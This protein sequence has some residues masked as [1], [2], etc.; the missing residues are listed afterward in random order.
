MTP[1]FPR[2]LPWKTV[3]GTSLFAATLFVPATAALFTPS[4]FAQTTGGTLSG[5]VTDATGAII[6][7]AP[8]VL[9]NVNSGDTRTLNS[10]SSGV[11]TFAGV[12]S[13]DYSIK[14][15]APGFQTFSESGIHL[16]PGDNRTL[17][18]LALKTG[19][20]TQTVTVEAQTDVP[21]DNGELSDLITS[22]EIKHLSVEGRDV[23]ELFKTLPGFAISN[24]NGGV[25]N[26]AYDPSQVNVTGALGSYAAN[27][28]PVSGISLRLDGADITDPGNFGAA[29]QNINYDQVAEVKVQVSNFGADIA[30]GP[31]VVS[32]VTKAGGDHFHGELYAY[33]RTNQL[34]SVDALDKATGTP[35]DPDREV[36]PGFNVGGPV[37]IPGT[38][39]NHN[40]KLTFFAGAEDY[41]QRNIYAYGSA[42][43]ALVHA[44]VPTAA[45]RTGNYSA[46]ELQNYLGPQ[47]YATG[48]ALPGVT[49]VNGLIPGS[50]YQFVDQ[51]PT[52]ASDGTPLANGQL[53]SN[54]QDPG[55]QAIFATYP[56]PNQTAT[57]ANPYNWQ[58]QDLINDDLWQAIGRVDLA[59]SDKNHF[60]GRYSVERG[61][62]GEPTALYYN[63]GGINT[64]GGGLSS[65]NSESA[66]ANLTTIFNS[67]L[68]NQLFG[69]LAYLNQS[70]VSPDPGA[71]TSYPYQGAFANGRHP[72]PQLQTY[73]VSD[74]MPLA[75]F[76][77]YSAGPIFAHKFTPQGGDTVTKVW[78]KHTVDFGVFIERVTNNELGAN[79]TTNGYLSNY[80][81]PNA[82]QTF[83]DVAPAGQ[84][85]ASYTMSGNYV[86]DNAEGFTQT[87]GQ[88]NILPQADLY[89][90]RNDFFAQDSWKMTQ[91]LTF[92]YGMRFEHLG[93]W[94]DAH[95][96]GI[97]IFEPSLLASGSGTSP[98]PGFV[99]HA[100]DP[101]VPNS[102]TASKPL[103]Y[104]GRVGFA[105]DVFG[106]GKTALRGGWGEYRSH[107]SWNDVQAAVNLTVG[108][109]TVTEGG[110]GV[111]LKGVSALNLS[112]APQLAGTNTFGAPTA[113]SLGGTVAPYGLTPGDNQEPL[114]DTYSLSINQA[115]PHHMNALIGYVGNNSRFIMNDGSNETVALDNVNAIPIGGLY[116]PDP[117][118]GSPCY[119]LVLTPTGVTPSGA[120]CSL[121]TAGAGAAQVNDYRPL[122]TPL[123]HYGAIDVPKH[124]L[125]AN[126]NAIQLALSKQTGRILFNLNYTFS[127]ALGILGGYNNGLPGNPFQLLDNYG[128]EAFDRSQI[129]NA[130]YTFELGSPVH[131]KLVGEVTNGWE[132]SGITN[133]QSGPDLTSITTNPGFAVSGTIGQP[134]LA[135]G[136]AN[137]NA[138]TINNAVY[139]GTPDVSLQPTLLCNPKSG[140][141]PHQFIN[142]NCFGT[143]NL[144]QNGPYQ[145]PYLHGPAYFDT[146]LSL[147]KAFD[148]THEQN[149]TFRISAF[150]FINHALTTFTGDFP[151]EY[152]LV[153]TNATG[154]S[155]NQ[156]VNNSALGFG[157]AQY[158]TGRRVVELSAKYNF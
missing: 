8:V 106:D 85:G 36:Y 69:A 108:S 98:Y 37:L 95:G 151:N 110:G 17:P 6:P 104:E 78:G 53:P 50:S 120:T 117:A 86:T 148:I 94:D 5:T 121:T 143:P 4:A 79:Y 66:A 70:F 134:F 35:K 38:R 18:Q 11:F 55:F 33:A 27:G 116:K 58:S 105:F 157:N 52:F 88:T 54:Y 126:Y 127:K 124:N 82:G 107:D 129:F 133:L 158:E 115:L 1:R 102:G 42:A 149:I 91:R 100:I 14:I 155:F 44:L 21:L 7:N 125:F 144:L 77:D 103:F 154:T 10:N 63:P 97:A 139:L 114:T 135:S 96:K 81:L 15:T 93:M 152:Q 68:T 99:W 136:A 60:F 64:P 132:L 146:D 31:I 65:I 67:T 25:T 46:T 73:T 45:M 150:N 84:T 131:N 145:Y 47:L 112:A 113:T 123:V 29:I 137:P 43:S 61:G 119:G 23:T 92:N 2:L 141:G 140:L 90:W 26:S 19:D 142:G 28:S 13:G 87:Y 153:E 56:L 41:A 39:F 118:I 16:D 80:Y 122:N 138:I 24:G 9:R 20:V 62:S 49:A 76:P 111:S 130:S 156:G 75:L 34:D 51:V 48:G 12:P 59:A 147:Q 101:S 72:L 71:L 109:T 32:A 57:L 3:L 128:P 83:T 89:F 30:N 22:E 74:G 40:R